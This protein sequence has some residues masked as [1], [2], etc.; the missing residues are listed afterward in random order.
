[1]D[2]FLHQLLSTP[3]AHRISYEAL[4]LER[5]NLSPIDCDLAKLQHL[6]EAH[7]LSD[8][9]QM[10]D[11]DMLSQFLFSTMME[12]DSAQETPLFVFN[13]PATQAA[14]AR[15]HPSNP[16]LAERFE[17]YI[18]GIE[19][20]NGFHELL[21]PHEQLQRFIQDQHKRHVNHSETIA[22]DERLIQALASGIPHCAGVALGVDRLI[23]IKL[24]TAHIK[25]VINFPW[26]CA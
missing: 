25:N 18:Q 17:V 11:R 8:A 9:N 22:I 12:R 19:L 3:T 10:T 14:L 15:L 23:M 26:D 6:S 1:M 16:K 20:A 5:L 24:K 7:G 4:F 2:E 13:F 21:D